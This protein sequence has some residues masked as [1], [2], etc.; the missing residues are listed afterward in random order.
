MPGEL[1]TITGTVPRK[2]TLPR[3]EMSAMKAL[4]V[5]H[6]ERSVD[7][8]VMACLSLK[9]LSGVFLKTKCLGPKSQM[10]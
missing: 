10:V 8:H 4:L 7:R 6:A 9:L 3:A 5:A 1:R 2:Q